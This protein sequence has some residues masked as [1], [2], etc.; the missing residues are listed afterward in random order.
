MTVQCPWYSLSLLGGNF[1]EIGNFRLLEKNS[2]NVCEFTTCSLHD[3]LRVC[4]SEFHASNTFIGIQKTMGF[5][6]MQQ[7]SE[8][9][10]KTK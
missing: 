10:G 8:V 2:K 6:T 1:C 9:G 7:I 5:F 3:A 4:K